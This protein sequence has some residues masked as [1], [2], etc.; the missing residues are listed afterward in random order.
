[1]KIRTKSVIIDTV[2]CDHSTRGGEGFQVR[3]IPTHDCSALA[4]QTPD[5]VK[6][7]QTWWLVWCGVVFCGYRHG[8][9]L[10]SRVRVDRREKLFLL[11][12][13]LVEHRPPCGFVA[14]IA[15]VGVLVTRA[16]RAGYCFR[17]F[18]VLV[19]DWLTVDCPLQ[20]RAN[21]RVGESCR[22]E[23]F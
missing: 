20:V 4:L 18:F 13:C 16:A 3:S 12:V 1:M 9:R 11:S 23:P 17:A 7:K 8:L 10:A 6:R 5:A 19:C 14:A 15:A 22:V 21:D 2:K